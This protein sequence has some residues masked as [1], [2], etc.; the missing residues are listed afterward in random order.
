MTD[1]SE[2]RIFLSGAAGFVGRS[3][4]D[5]FED[6]PVRALVHNPLPDLER[7]ANV[8]TVTGDVTNP[9]TLRGTMDGCSI[10]V[11]LVAVIEESGGAT[12]DEV[13]RQ[14]TENMLSEAKQA[15]I[16]RFIHMSAL[17]AHDNPTY[18]YLQAKWRA[19]QAVKESGLQ[20]TI[21]R[22][23]VIFGPGDGFINALAGVVRGFPI[24]PV[25]GD[26]TARFQP[27]AVSDVA[28]C[29]VR[30]IDDPKT[31][32][33]ETFELGGGTVYTYEELLG[34]IAS[35]L[36]TSKRKVHVPV[37]VMKA[38][39]ALSSPLPKALR[40]PVTSE[41]LK[42]LA[43]DNTTED[44]ATERLIGSKPMSLEDALGYIS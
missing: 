10:V 19:E 2:G 3:I 21:F 29:Y 20:Y 15:G 22:P 5:Q 39:V 16:D 37:S 38:V 30:A 23:S 24:V 8:E 33:G 36:G 14:G 13:I 35:E 26:G 34:L 17:G 40:P 25:V 12:F 7:R 44:S 18:G 4:L 1:L 6:R 31:T 28:R 41:Q 11:H 43:L 42:M 32:A 9:A 27:V